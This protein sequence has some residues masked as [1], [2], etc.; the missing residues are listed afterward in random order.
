MKSF[1]PAQQDQQDRYLRRWALGFINLTVLGTF[2]ADVIV[3]TCI[4]IEY[5][6]LYYF[7]KIKHLMSIYKT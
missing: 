2:F 3:R 7:K 6:G 5:I 4:M 1:S